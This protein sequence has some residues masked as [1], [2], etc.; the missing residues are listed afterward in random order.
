MGFHVNSNNY[1]L[2]IPS[3]DHIHI[4]YDACIHL[5]VVMAMKPLSKIEA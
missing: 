3:L 4:T 1:L 5:N 2:V